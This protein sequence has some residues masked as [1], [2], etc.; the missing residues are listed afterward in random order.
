MSKARGHEASLDGSAEAQG[1]VFETEHYDYE[2]PQ[3]LIAQRP[4][5]QRDQARLLVL[6][7]DAVAH[8]RFRD[9]P[10]YVR[11]GDLFVANDARVLR[12][13]FR[14]ERRGGGKAEVLLLHPA[15]PG[16]DDAPDFAHGVVWEAM[17]RPSA[18]VRDG[19]RLSLS[20]HS[21]IEVLGHA[22]PSTRLVRFYGF[23]A[24]EAM[25]NYG[26]MPLPPYI[27]APPADADERYQ[28][29]Y[30]RHE[31]AIAA[32]TAGLHFTP[33]LIETLRARGAGWATI[34]LDVGAGT[35]VP[36]KSADIREH[37]MHAERYAICADTARAVRENKAAGGRV[38]AV[39]TTTVRCLEDAA[40]R[41]AGE[42]REG[43]R[44]TDLFIYPGFEFRVVD[45]MIT[46]FHLPRSTLL[47]LVSA[48]AGT[49][50]L[51]DAYAEA[52]RENYRFYSFGD[53]MFIGARAPLA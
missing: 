46:N 41:D 2:L 18:R 13:R 17:V 48:F 16:S 25:R 53:A 4:A 36:V 9:L 51:I 31:G 30:A 1:A 47:M 38:I 8:R 22:T 34:T 10:E 43:S 24:D 42:V 29:V 27:T 21:G 40:L 52:V 32:P 7:G 6:D 33:A 37:P 50:R 3:E 49:Q 26:I 28:T 23:D 14:P 44:L 5:Q 11:P 45:A 35:F 19:D 39:G 15:D 12:A 20:Q